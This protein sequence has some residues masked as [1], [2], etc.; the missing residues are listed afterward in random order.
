M[1]Q[2][3]CRARHT[4]FASRRLLDGANA[5]TAA[6]HDGPTPAADA[7][8]GPGIRAAQRLTCGDTPTDPW[9]VAP[10]PPDTRMALRIAFGRSLELSGHS[11]PMAPK[12]P[13][14]AQIASRHGRSPGWRMGGGAWGW[15]S[16]M[17]H[18]GGTG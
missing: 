9:A 8:E 2:R 4:V 12:I 5:R 15:V 1:R 7:A 16:S 3:C 10:W 14:P 11:R 6:R 17:S 13:R 18:R